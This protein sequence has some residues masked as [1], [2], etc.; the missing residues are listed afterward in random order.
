[1]PPSIIEK[2]WTDV[3]AFVMYAT[4]GEALLFRDR[5]YRALILA[6]TAVD[7]LFGVDLVGLFS[8]ADGFFWADFCTR[9]TRNALIG[10]DFPGHSVLLT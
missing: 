8:L 7:A 1:M 6:H 5:V 4:A 9:T 3:Q 10:V 2:A